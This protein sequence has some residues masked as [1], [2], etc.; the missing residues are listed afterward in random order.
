MPLLQ[1][2]LERT[3]CDFSL[4]RVS[5]C[6]RT[7]QA[8]IMSSW[9][10]ELEIRKSVFLLLSESAVEKVSVAAA[11]AVGWKDRRRGGRKKEE[12]G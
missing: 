10:E 4:E 9:E 12:V 3:H 11:A 6:R 1:C 7:V 8:H 2:E 5:A